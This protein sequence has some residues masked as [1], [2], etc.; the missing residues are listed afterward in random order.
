[1]KTITGYRALAKVAKQQ[2]KIAEQAREQFLRLAICSWV[3][4]RRAEAAK[5]EAS[6]GYQECLKEY[7]RRCAQSHKKHIAKLHLLRALRYLKLAAA[8]STRTIQ[9]KGKEHDPLA[10]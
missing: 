1:M 9:N 6:L 3:A 8:A 2:R 7:L 10:Y 4:D 5:I